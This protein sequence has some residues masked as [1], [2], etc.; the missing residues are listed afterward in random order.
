[1]RDYIGEYS[2]V[3]FDTRV[4]V[5]FYKPTITVLIDHYINSKYLKV[6]LS[7]MRIDKRK[8]CINNISPNLLQLWKNM[9]KKPFLWIYFNH[10]LIQL[11]IWQL[12]R[13]LKFTILGKIFLNSIISQ[14]NSWLII[15]QGIW[16]R[17]SSNISLLIKV[18]AY[19]T[20]DWCDHQVVTE[21]EFSILIEEWLLD[22]GLDDVGSEAAVVVYFFVF[23]VVFYLF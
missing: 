10:I 17:S 19:F 4:G 13:F 16:I 14:M 3:Y 8:R 21:I 6:I 9:I 11:L 12:I 2:A 1:M 20:L 18:P 23:Y 15:I 22:V 7:S 5:N